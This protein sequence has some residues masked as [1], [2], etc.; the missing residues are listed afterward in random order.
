LGIRR[1]G[2]WVIGWAVGL[3]MLGLLWAINWYDGIPHR[4]VARFERKRCALYM[5]RRYAEA[6]RLCERFE[7]SMG[8]PE[9]SAR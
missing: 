8:W 4:R 2:E 5:A 9:G 1:A 6:E 3:P 7:R